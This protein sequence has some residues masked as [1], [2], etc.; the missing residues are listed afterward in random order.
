ML[1]SPGPWS[2]R[3]SASWAIS[4]GVRWR[5]RLAASLVIQLQPHCQPN[6]DQLRYRTVFR[7][8]SRL[9][10]ALGSAVAATVLL[11]TIA[12]PSVL[13]GTTAEAAVPCGSTGS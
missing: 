7:K 8:S 13:L 5:S 12:T 4:P 2:N 6:T 10:S 3:R 1:G 11:A 9:Q